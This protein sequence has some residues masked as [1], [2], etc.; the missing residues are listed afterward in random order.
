MASSGRDEA[1][2]RRER[3]RSSAAI[4]GVFRR[5][6]RIERPSFLALWAADEERPGVAF[7]ASRQAGS[8][9]ERNRARR[10]V[11]EA[12]RRQ[13][14]RVPGGLAVVFVARPGAVSSRF[15]EIV[16]D[17]RAAIATM[18]AQSRSGPGRGRAGGGSDSGTD[19]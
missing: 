3:L 19:G 18:S 11:R 9:P 7:A 14:H 5:G 4:Q 6:R 8:V 17:I 16:A 1:L 15:P 12:Y 13:A 2:G 10:R